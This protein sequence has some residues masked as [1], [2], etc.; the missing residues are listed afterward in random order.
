MP[1]SRNSR[2]RIR[3]MVVVS[4]DRA[5]RPLFKLMRGFRLSHGRIMHKQTTYQ[6]INIY[7]DNQVHSYGLSHDDVNKIRTVAPNP[8]PL[9]ATADS[10][11]QHTYHL[12]KTRNFLVNHRIFIHLSLSNHPISLC[13]PAVPEVCHLQQLLLLPSEPTTTSLNMWTTS[14][15]LNMWT[16]SR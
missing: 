8:K 15:S 16:T 2:S 1:S 9:V 12:Q 3:R 5:Y 7:L 6:T 11:I 14:T 10:T 4:S 13:S